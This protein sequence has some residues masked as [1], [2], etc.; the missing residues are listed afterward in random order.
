MAPGLTW[1]AST[2]NVAAAVVVQRAQRTTFEWS[3][4][5][6]HVKVYFAYD[7]VIVPAFTAMSIPA[8]VE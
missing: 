7:V 6:V 1:M 5:G 3:D 2:R 4:V 8:V